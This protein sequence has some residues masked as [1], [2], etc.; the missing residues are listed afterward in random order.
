MLLNIAWNQI[1]HAIQVSVMKPSTFRKNY[2][3]ITKIDK[4]KND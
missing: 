3:A 1:I 2:F 4:Y